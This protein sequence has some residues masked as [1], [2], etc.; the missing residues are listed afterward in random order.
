MGPAVVLGNEQRLCERVDMSWRFRVHIQSLTSPRAVL[1]P[2]VV[3]GA[4][5]STWTGHLLQPPGGAVSPRACLPQQATE[6]S[7]LT[8]QEVLPLALTEANSPD[9]GVA[10]P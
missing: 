2:V 5:V 10:W 6:P 3:L 9:G 4:N 7:V 1:N 8:P